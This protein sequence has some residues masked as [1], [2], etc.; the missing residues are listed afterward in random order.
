MDRRRLLQHK[1]NHFFTKIIGRRILYNSYAGMASLALLRTLP[2]TPLINPH[3]NLT[4]II[5]IKRATGRE[6]LLRF[7][8]KKGQ[9]LPDQ[10]VRLQLH[11]S[12]RIIGDAH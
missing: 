7:G 5:R 10:H 12:Q 6:G 3:L 11:T 9:A 2:I 8:P 1:I 4:K